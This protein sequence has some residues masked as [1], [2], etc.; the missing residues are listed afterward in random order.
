MND[1]LLEAKDWIS[2]SEAGGGDLGPDLLEGGGGSDEDSDVLKGEAL[3]ETREE[4]EVLLWIRRGKIKKENEE[5]RVSC[6]LLS[7]R[8]SR[9]CKE[10][11]RLTLETNNLPRLLCF[12]TVTVLRILGA[13]ISK[14]A[15]LDRAKMEIVRAPQS[16]TILSKISRGKDAL[17]GTIS[18]RGSVKVERVSMRGNLGKTM[19]VFAILRAEEMVQGRKVSDSTPSSF[20]PSFERTLLHPQ[21][22]PTLSWT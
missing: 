20:S 13:K 15:R 16:I 2:R 8:R 6:E 7:E 12:S 3:G 17:K 1:Q 18:G 19:V 10:G 14:H 5:E 11:R 9:G 21:A 4:F 22:F